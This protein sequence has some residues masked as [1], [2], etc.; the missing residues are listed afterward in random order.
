VAGSVSSTAWVKRALFLVIVGLVVQLFCLVDITPGSFMI[1]AGAGVGA[2]GLGWCM[3]AFGLWRV[4]GSRT[5]GDVDD[6]G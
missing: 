3:L 2:V 1:F 5:K 4:R 6:E